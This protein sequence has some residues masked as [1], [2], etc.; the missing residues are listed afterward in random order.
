MPDSLDESLTG[1][2]YLVTGAARGIGRAQALDLAARGAVVAVADRAGLQDVVDDATALGA[3]VH[4]VS[5]D[6]RDGAAVQAAVDDL[7]AR[8]GRLDGVCAT[9]GVCHG[10]GPFWELDEADVRLT[11]E[12][13][14][15]ATW[16]VL[17]AAARHWVR[18]GGP[19]AVVVTGSVAASRGLPGVGHYVASK[20]AQQGLVRTAARELGPYG[21]R[22][23]AVAPTN[24]DTPLLQ[25]EEVWQIMTGSTEEVSREAAAEAA[26]ASHH[27]PVPWVQPEDV[28]AATTWLL[29]DAARYVTGAIIPVD[30]GAMDH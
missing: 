26:C 19:G 23:N 18:A 24:V 21:V 9:A 6:L 25:R 17:A 22:V 11:L 3:R 16:T 27:L 14:V 28:A 12:T 8:E 13:N 1:R 2:V 7:V 15:M 10:Y 29:S 30:A 20:H 4:P 5:L